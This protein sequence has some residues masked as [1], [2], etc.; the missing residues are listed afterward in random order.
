MS[1]IKVMQIQSRDFSYDVVVAPTLEDALNEIFSLPDVY[2]LADEAV[3]KLYR[4]AFEAPGSKPIFQVLADESQKSIDLVREIC[5][6]LL[7][8]G[9][10]KTSILIAV[11]GGVVQDLATFVSHIY[12]RGIEWRYC[13]TTLLSMAD[14]CIGAKC[15][16]NLGGHKN[17]IGVIHA[18]SLVYLAPSVL[19]TLPPAEMNS[20]MGEILKLSVTGAAEFYEEFKRRA[21]DPSALEELILAS[22]RSKQVIIEE[23]EYESDLRRVLNYGHSF[24][25][26][27]ESLTHHAV[28]H[29]EAI[30]FG[31]DLINFLG[32]RWGITSK[33]FEKDFRETIRKFFPEVSLPEGISANDLVGELRR[34]KKLQHGRMVFAVPSDV[35]DLRLVAK[36]LDATLIS[37]VEE[38][39]RNGWP[40]PSS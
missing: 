38:F 2:V 11:G 15:A 30:L 3:V 12:Y 10:T 18:P 19:N 31:M 20:G 4:S 8:Q 21:N 7:T 28:T 25:H 6:W 9:A 1:F 35:G 33:N 32:V 29:G 14:S 17:Q 36:D 37:E 22:L 27:L 24:G 16:L 34:D 23:D 5:E 39:I 13:P 40:V 26:A